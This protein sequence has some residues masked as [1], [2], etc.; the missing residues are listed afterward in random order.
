MLTKVE[1]VILGI[2]ENHQ[3]TDNVGDGYSERR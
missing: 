3:S 1:V 2:A